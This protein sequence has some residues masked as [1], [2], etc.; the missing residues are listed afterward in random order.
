[1][2]TTVCPVVRPLGVKYDLKTNSGK[3]EDERPR[4]P[5][6]VLDVLFLVLTKV[7]R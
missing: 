6:G 3:G 7:E 1:M 5:R 4:E 2:F